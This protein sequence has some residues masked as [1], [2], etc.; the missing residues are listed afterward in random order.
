MTIMALSDAVRAFSHAAQ[1]PYKPGIRIM[2]AAAPKAWV[3]APVA[4][5]LRNWWGNDLDLSHF[6]KP[7]NEYDSVYDVSRIK[8]EIGFVA[9]KFPGG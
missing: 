1:S 8:N 7:G 2:N 9:E 6:E 5:I 4:E 3:A